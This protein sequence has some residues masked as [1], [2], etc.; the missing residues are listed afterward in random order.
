MKHLLRTAVLTAGVMSVLLC[1]AGTARASA[2]VPNGTYKCY[3]FGYN[4][5]VQL[6]SIGIL[7]ITGPN[8]Y[9]D[10]VANYRTAKSSPAFGTFTSTPFKRMDEYA[11]LNFKGTLLGGHWGYANRKPNGDLAIIFPN[12]EKEKA[13]DPGATWCYYSK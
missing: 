9:R 2:V 10:D 3:F 4:G 8:A 1:A 13:F 12:N 11:K 7:H 6:S 5:G